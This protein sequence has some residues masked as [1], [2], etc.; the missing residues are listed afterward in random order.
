MVKAIKISFI[1][2]LSLSI[3][4]IATQTQ[5]VIIRIPEGLLKEIDKRIANGYYK[6]RQDFILAA[7]REN[8]GK[9]RPPSVRQG[10]PI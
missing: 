8:I 5:Q 3:V 9:G 6:N 7:L 4:M 1:Y 10:G 2:L